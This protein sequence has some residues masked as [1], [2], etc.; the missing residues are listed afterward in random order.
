MTATVHRPA[1]G[2]GPAD[3]RSATPPAR[4]GPPR[5]A[6]AF[7]VGPLL[8]LAGC[9]RSARRPGVL[10]A[11]YPLRAVDVVTTSGAADRPRPARTTSLASPQ[12]AALGLAFGVADRHGARAG[13]GPV[14]GSGEALIDGPIQIKRAIP[15][16]ALIPLLILWF[17]IGEQM[18][19]ITIAL[20]G[21]V[22]IYIHTHNGLRGID[23]RYVEL[24]ETL[25]LSRG[26]V[27][28]P[29]RAARRAARLPARACGSR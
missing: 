12:R 8:L 17:G 5:S 26:D 23:S 16:L 3:A 6:S 28:P 10:D 14:A 13:L 20:V 11:A 18:K 2:R 15:T 29:R 19:V 24:A 27:P 9:G 7:C 1:A 4:A 22:P 21:F 25:G